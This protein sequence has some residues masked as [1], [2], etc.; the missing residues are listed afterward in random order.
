MHKVHDIIRKPNILSEFGL[1]QKVNINKNDFKEIYKWEYEQD[2][3]IYSDGYDEMTWFV[4]SSLT[5]WYQ[6]IYRHKVIVKFYI[7][8][9]KSF[10]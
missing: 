1:T 7:C 10:S 6:N 8:L 4:S 9:N 3:I 2:F 5:D